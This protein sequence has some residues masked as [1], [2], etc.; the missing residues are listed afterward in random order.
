MRL[1]VS[2]STYN[3]L[4]GLMHKEGDRTQHGDPLPLHG[5]EI[6]PRPMP[7]NRPANRYAPIEDDA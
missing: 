6:E 2:N 1:V 5:V 4:L 3:E 7:L